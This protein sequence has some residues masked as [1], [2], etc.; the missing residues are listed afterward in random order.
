MAPGEMEPI[1]LMCSCGQ[2]LIKPAS[3]TILL[4]GAARD[5]KFGRNETERFYEHFGVNLCVLG[6][7]RLRQK[8][9]RHAESG[10]ITKS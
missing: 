1:G 2:G 6:R 3:G 5:L 8:E 10:E 9:A 7:I 4:S